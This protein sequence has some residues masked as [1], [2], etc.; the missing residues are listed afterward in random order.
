M[1][2]TIGRF[3]LGNFIRMYIHSI[4]GIENIP[5]GTPFITAANH[6]SFADDLMLPST[7]LR[8]TNKKFHIFVNSRFYKNYFLSKF[9]YIYGCIPVDVKK[10]VGNENNRKQTNEAAFK[11][12]ITS[13]KMGGTFGIFPEGG[14]S[15]DGK[16]K[17]AKLGVAR[18][19]LE[20]RVPVLP[21]GIKG[22]YKIM[23]KGAKFPRFKRAEIIIGKP[24]YFDSFY[25]K[26]KDYKTLELVTRKIMKEIA[27]LTEQEY[28]Y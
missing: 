26:E 9:F 25:G 19:A 13:L 18:I 17:K 28:N 3:I 16:L 11:E 12:A 15:E 6:A 22:S 21:F 7:I 8:Y 10:D 2:Y 5:K 1:V 14:R 27:K 4:K 20:A 23:P 24:L